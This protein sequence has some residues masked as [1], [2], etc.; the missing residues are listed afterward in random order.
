MAELIELIDV[1]D[2]TARAIYK[3]PTLP[4][5]SIAICLSQSLQNLGLSLDWEELIE[6]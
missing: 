5:S 3:P 2:L 1:T 6:L 4:Y